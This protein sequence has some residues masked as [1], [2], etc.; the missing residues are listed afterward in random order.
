[1]RAK[2]S[3]VLIG[4]L[5]FGHAGQTAQE[6]KDKG[7]QGTWKLVSF[8]VNSESRDFTENP[9]WWVIEKNKV[10][11]GGTELA[12]IAAD[13]TTT[14]KCFDLSFKNP[15]KTLEGIYAIE[16]EKLKIC[17]NSQSD[18]VKER[19]SSFD[20]KD[21]P[22]WR[23]LVFQRVKDRKNSTEGLG[24]FVGMMIMGNDE[25]NDI[26][27]G[28]TLKGSPAEKAG[29]KKDDVLLQIGTQKAADLQEVVAA[30][31]RVRPGNDL[32][33]RINRGG[34]EQDI[35]LKVGVVPFMYFD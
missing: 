22:G 3:L 8:E 21:H 24:G 10:L 32:T 16:G 27:I 30:V 25:T 13:A 29:L 9:P 15:Q 26:V 7:L 35:T 18:G 33:L 1:M 2:L 34:K 6:A 11:Y 5:S 23:L 4:F 17:V 31:R 20:V 14:P 19:P 28:G 12:E